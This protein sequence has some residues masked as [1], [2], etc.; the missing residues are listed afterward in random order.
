MLLADE[1]L[2]VDPLHR[3]PYFTLHRVVNGYIVNVAG[4]NG[5]PSEQYICL[6]LSQAV[7]LLLEIV[8]RYETAC[9]VEARAK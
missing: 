8:C 5:Q 2:P 3:M 7:D 9:G 6:R 4:T 1:Q